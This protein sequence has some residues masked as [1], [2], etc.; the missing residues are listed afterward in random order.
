MSD[1]DYGIL[2]VH[3]LASKRCVLHGADAWRITKICGDMGCRLSEAMTLEWR[4]VDLQNDQ[5]HFERTKNDEPRALPMRRDI[6]QLFLNYPEDKRFGRVFSEAYTI[7]NYEAVWNYCRR[8]MGQEGNEYWVPHILRHRVA[9]QL[10]S[11]GH[12]LLEIK[13]WLGHKSL[14]SV[15]VYAHLVKG[16]LKKLASSLDS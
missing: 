5:I 11:K 3:M 9:S 10:A 15:M 8:L 16:H 12:N 6:K 14:A 13:D 1:E 2:L 4:N 7:D